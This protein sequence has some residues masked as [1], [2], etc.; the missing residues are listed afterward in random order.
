[1]T[2]TLEN[3]ILATNGKLITTTNT[4]IVFT[5]ISTDSRNLE[6]GALYIAIKGENFD[7]HKFIEQAFAK[8]AVVALV[9]AL[10]SENYPSSN[11]LIQV[12]DTRLALGDFAKWHRQHMNLQHL[13][14]IT[15]SNGKTT[16]KSMVQ[17]ILTSI[18]AKNSILATAGNLN[19][20]F[21]VPRTLLEIKPEHKIAVIEMGANQHLE[22]NYVSKLA[23]PNIALIT[24][25]ALAHIEGFGSLDGVVKTKSE[26]MD[27]LSAGG[28]IVLNTDSY[29][30]ETWQN[31]AKQKQLNVLSF[32]KAKNALFRLINF[33]QNLSSLE[34]SFSFNSKTYQVNM[35]ILGEH[36]ALNALAS[37]AICFVAGFKLNDLLM[38]LTSFTG[39]NGRLAQLKLPNGVFIDDSY[40]ANPDSVKAAIKTLCSVGVKSVFCMGIMSEIGETSA[41]EHK[42]IA[43]YAKQQGVSFLLCCGEETKLMPKYFGKNAFW[44]ENQ[45][46]LANEAVKLIKTKQV[47]SCLVKGSRVS[48]MEKVVKIILDE[49]N[50]LTPK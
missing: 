14:A 45:Q 9:S 16:C 29:G 22:I 18:A 7:G 40:N 21:G 23:Q 5:S 32:G 24:I 48:K 35:P 38:P 6:K 2:W 41:Q 11:T 39:V 30:F 20:D 44:F 43:Q 4:Q 27:G 1:M 3:L 49:L 34:F 37:I 26:V 50:T 15:G 8:G 36:N 42:N 46:Q 13:I 47:D 12:T 10:V 31:I 19:N 28:T 25:A 33:K 17:H